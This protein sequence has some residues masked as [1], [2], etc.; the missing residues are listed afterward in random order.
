[1]NEFVKFPK[2]PR[3]SR[4]CV[5]TEKIDGTNGQIYIPEEDPRAMYV[6]SRS[7]WITPENDNHGFAKWCHANQ[8]ELIAKL[9]PGLHFG[10]WW[11]QGIQRNYGLREKRFSLFKLKRWE[12]VDVSPCHVVPW[13]YKGPF[14]P[15]VDVIMEGLRTGGSIAVPGYMNPEGIVIFHEAGNL[16][17]KKTLDNDEGKREAY[18]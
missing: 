17:F 4:E 13:F 1:M 12:G 9:G 3:W 7:R 16:L 5:V 2:I 15:P 14:P 10:E 18:V 8:E 11:G 6:G